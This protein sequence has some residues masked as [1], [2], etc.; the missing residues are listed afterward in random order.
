MDTQEFIRQSILRYGDKGFD[1]SQVNYVNTHT[2]V[3]IICNH[4][5]AFS[6]RPVKH[7]HNNQLCPVCT[8]EERLQ[9]AARFKSLDQ[10][11]EHCSNVHQCAFD[12]V[13]IDTSDNAFNIITTNSKLKCYCSLHGTFIQTV[14]KHIYQRTGCPQCGNERSRML[15]VKS[16]QQFIQDAIRVQGNVYQYD[17]VKYVNAHTLVA[18][19]CSE[20]GDFYQSPANHILKEQGC[21]LCSSSSPERII[22]QWLTE[23]N[24]VHIHQY[25]DNEC[26]GVNDKPLRF[27]FFL[28]HNGI[29]I[30]YDGIY[31]FQPIVHN[32]DEELA[33]IAFNNSQI[34]DNIKNQYAKDNDY[35]MVRIPYYINDNIRTYLTENVLP[36]LSSSHS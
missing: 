9:D 16:T 28:P 32:Q 23:H 21:P 17:N 19:T 31:H 12:Y 27:D 18:I 14:N 22:S 33:N 26:S 4:H 1:Y 10:L 24:I 20:H 2:K 36:L 7:L 25:K 8:E 6:V 13:S 3:S 35:V 29:I 5:G 30:E 11:I 15:R 34:H